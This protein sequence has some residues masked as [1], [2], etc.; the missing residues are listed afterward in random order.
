MWGETGIVSTVLLQ[1]TQLP[2]TIPSD[3]AARDTRR[4]TK[5]GTALPTISK[6]NRFL[7]PATMLYYRLHMACAMLAI[8]T[9]QPEVRSKQS[10]RPRPRHAHAQHT[11]MRTDTHDHTC[12]QTHHVALAPR[13]CCLWAPALLLEQHLT[14]PLNRLPCPPSLPRPFPA[15]EVVRWLS[16]SQDHRQSGQCHPSG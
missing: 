14:L 6:Y 15:G 5:R 11:N 13:G 12:A 8:V 7:S 16:H 1:W 10:K 3:T 2:T 4:G 9:A